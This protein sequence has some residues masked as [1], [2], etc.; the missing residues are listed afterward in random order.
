M[1]LV[2]II[3]SLR[4]EA[5]GPTYS[6]TSLCSALEAATHHVQLL[7]QDCGHLAK[8]PD[9]LRLFPGGLVPARLGRTPEMD[10]WI[11]AHCDDGRIDVLHNH[12][13]WHMTAIYPARAAKRFDVPFVQSPRGAF[14]EWAM[15]WG[16]K[17][18]PA[19]WRLL[20]RPALRLA[21]CFHATAEAE[22]LDIRRLGFTQPVAILPNGIDVPP[23]TA[24]QRG[25]MRTLLFLGRLHFN[26]GLDLLLRAW[27]AVQH[28][29]PDWQLRIVGNDDGYLRTCNALITELS[30]Q[31][32]SMQGPLYGNEKLQ[33]F[34]DADLSVLPTYSENFA[35]T[36]AESLSLATP[37]IVSK[38]APWPGLA[39][40]GCGWWIDIG[41]EP[42]VAALEE[43]LSRSPVELEQMGERGR[44]WMVEDFSWQDIGR[45]MA[46]TYEWLRD[47]SLPVPDWVRLK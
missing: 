9:Y 31:R 3:P 30:L 41:V 32:V 39:A 27:G 37:A 17:L 20:Q 4:D 10:S 33:A 26:K 40:R 11:R 35:M 42:L 19:F 47:P 45:K 36:V 16:S 43:A 5:S 8:R 2:H 14:T 24:R 21:S 28:G 23:L 29:H 18:K 15:N 38:G 22:Y 13:L 1:R 12:G 34:R 46:L 7:A 44:K 6:V 25:E